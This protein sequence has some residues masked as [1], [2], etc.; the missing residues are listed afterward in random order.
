MSKPIN[1]LKKFAEQLIKIWIHA[2]D[3]T[4]MWWM[5]PPFLATAG[6]MN[7]KRILEHATSHYNRTSGAKGTSHSGA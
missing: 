3:R 5:S 4:S 2:G 6:I 7:L 1:C